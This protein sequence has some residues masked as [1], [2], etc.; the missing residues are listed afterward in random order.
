MNPMQ[1]FNNGL[2]PRFDPKPFENLTADDLNIDKLL[3]LEDTVSSQLPRAPTQ[4]RMLADVPALYAGQ[5]EAPVRFDIVSAPSA[6][7]FAKLQQRG[8]VPAT[9]KPAAEA[10]R[11]N[12]P[13]PDLLSQVEQER[14]KV[15]LCVQ[16]NRER[17]LL[18]KGDFAIRGDKALPDVVKL[19]SRISE[20]LNQID[21]SAAAIKRSSEL[22]RAEVSADLKATSQQLKRLKAAAPAINITPPQI[23]P[24]V[25][26]APQTALPIITSQNQNLT[27]VEFTVQ[28]F[29][30]KHMGVSAS[31]VFVL[32]DIPFTIKFEVIKDKIGHN[33]NIVLERANQ[34]FTDRPGLTMI[35]LRITCPMLEFYSTR[36][37]KDL[38][39]LFETV[40]SSGCDEDFPLHDTEGYKYATRVPPLRVPAKKWSAILTN[41]EA[42]YFVEKQNNITLSLNAE[43][44]ST[45]SV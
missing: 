18:V 45:K 35:K 32:G 2:T 28:D 44:V 31:P 15:L 29:N 33:V 19:A 11:K 10:I 24:V 6:P 40:P 21:L 13:E 38:Y 39:A 26:P 4:L 27:K 5:P 12:S 30:S 22:T 9:Q 41:L 42:L 25:A 14:R 3:G 37:N 20:S 43:F 8:P 36:L 16:E 17:L 23:I 1:P 7:I 34:V